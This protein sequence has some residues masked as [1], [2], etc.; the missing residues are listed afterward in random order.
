MKREQIRAR[1]YQYVS[2]KN[3]GFWWQK[4]EKSELV[5][6][7]TDRGEVVPD[8]MVAHRTFIAEANLIM[9]VLAGNSAIFILDG[10]QNVRIDPANSKF[11]FDS[12]LDTP[13]STVRFHGACTADGSMEIRT[14]DFVTATFKDVAQLKSYIRIA[15]CEHNSTI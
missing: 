4:I 2:K 8:E 7:D 13:T 10:Y 12:S 1:V 11:Y 3:R 15:C 6:L 5:D 9:C 14:D